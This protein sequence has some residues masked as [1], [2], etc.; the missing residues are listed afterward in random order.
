MMQ[1]ESGPRQGGLDS[2][3]GEEAKI[4]SGKYRPRELRIELYDR[5]IALRQRGLSYS[6]IRDVIKQEYGIELNRGQIS[7]WVRGVHSPY[8]GWRGWGVPSLKLLEPSEDLAY[9]I[10]VVCGD[11]YVGLE[12]R[13]KG[14]GHSKIRLIAKDKEF[15]EEFAIRIGR[16]LNRPPKLKVQ[17]TTGYYC[18][19]A[20]SKTLYKLLKKP[21][22]LERLRKYIEHCDKCSAAF[23]RGF[24]DSEGSVTKTGSISVSN[25]DYNLLR[26]VQSLLRRFEILTTGP[27]LLFQRGTIKHS[28]GKQY[29]CRRDIYYVYVRRSCNIG[30]YKHIGFTIKRKQERLLNYLRRTGRLE[31]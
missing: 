31:Y 1:T 14:Y 29:I 24:F 9:V 4:I 19:E 13:H 22:D 21:I 10:G 11:G 28:K 17:R 7:E 30:F 5:V 15:V 12:K 25:S 23:L 8:N 16:V 18:F 27:H 20:E 26:Y 2:V 6:K 3:R